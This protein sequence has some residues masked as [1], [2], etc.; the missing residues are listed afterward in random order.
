VSDGCMATPQDIR[1]RFALSTWLRVLLLIASTAGN[2][3]AQSGRTAEVDAAEAGAAEAGAPS[4][5][6]ACAVC[7][8]A[9]A[10]GSTA[11]APRL[12]GQNAD[13]MAHALFMF[14]ARTRAGAAMQAVA[15][16]LTERQMHDLAAYFSTQHPPPVKSEPAP[17]GQLVAAGKSLA[18]SGAGAD[19]AACFSCHAA[20]GQGNGARFPRIAGQPQKFVVDRL[21]EF[22]QR[23]KGATPKPGTMTAVSAALTE[24]QIIQV[25]SY[26]S[27]MPE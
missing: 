16:N 11:G 1:M 4:G 9:Q 10:A 26:L 7:H 3:Y 6:A 2:G 17:A 12:A 22:Q 15:Q 18:E 25:A 5:T 8:G 27:V 19:L 24:R 13:Y 21:H 20:G 14:K 23:A